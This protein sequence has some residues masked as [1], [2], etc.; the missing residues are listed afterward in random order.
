MWLLLLVCTTV[1]AQN[2]VNDW[3]NPAMPSFNTV[4]AHAWFVPYNNESEALKNGSSPN[5]LSLDGT[6]KFNL[7]N[8]VEE[9]PLDFYK[10]NFNTSKWND[11]KVP[12]SWQTEGFDKYIFT[13][14]EYPIPPNPPF[15]PKEF[16]PV[17]SYK[18]SFS[19]PANWNGKNVFIHLGAVNSF[20]YLWIND[21]YVGFS[22]DSKTAA[23]FDISPFLKKGN[24]TVSIQVF[25]FSDGTY[26]EGQDMWK[27]S[28]I[29][30]SVYLI[31]R[32]KLSIADF[33][34]K[35]TLD[36]KYRDGLFDLELKM[37]RSPENK[38]LNQQIQIKVIDE[39]NGNAILLDQKQNIPAN[40]K[41]AIKKIFND[42]KKWNAETPNLY[43]LVINTLTAEGKSIESISR[44]IGFRTAE[45]KHGLFLINGV[46]V[47][48]KGVN[49]HEFNSI[50]GKVITRPEM[51]EDIRIFKQY[52]INAV[53]SSHYPNAPEW[54]ELCDQYGIYVV[55]EVNIE[56][57]GMSFSPL[58]TL[59]DKPEWLKAYM[60]RTERMFEIN[61]NF[62]SI[63]TW[64]LGNE[65]E[66][67]SNM[68]ATYTY[69]K[70]KDVTR[71]VAYEPASRTQYSDIFFPM[72]KSLNLMQEYVKEWRDK[73]YI[74]CE[75]AHMMGNGGGNLKDYWDLIYKYEQ[76]QGGYIWD[77]SDQAFRIK[78]SKGRAI[79]GYGR[80][81]GKV[82]ETSDTSFC[83][84]G[85]FTSDRQPHP[86][87]FELKRVYQN[88]NFEPTPF[89]KNQITIFNRFD[90][91]DL[92]QYYFD[93]YIKADG[94]IVAQG[95]IE[96]FN[97]APHQSKV[98]TLKIPELNPNPGTEYF[99]TI[100]GKTK[101]AS[102]LLPANYLMAENQF[103]LPVFK[104]VSAKQNIAQ[105]LL[106]MKENDE[107]AEVK[108]D[109]FS[110]IFNK[111]TGWLEAYNLQ[112]TAIMK[113]AL[114]PHFWRAATDNDI[115]NSQ[116]IRCAMWKDPI[117]TASLRSFTVSKLNGSS[118]QI[119]TRHYLPDVK[120]FYEVTYL[121]MG[122][123]EIKVNASM[124][125]S[126]EYIPEM[127]RFGMRMLLNKDFENVKWLGRGPFDN[128]QDRNYS[129][130]IDVYEMPADSLF[131]PYARAQESGYR[132]D[133][134][135]M[136]LVNKSGM[137]L[138]AVGAPTISTGVL[139]FDMAKLDYYKDAPE[140][141]HGGSMT[142]EDFVW[143]NIDY[144][145]M[146]VGGDNSWG[147][148]PHGQ[149]LLPYRDYHYTFTIKP[150]LPGDNVIE[151]SKL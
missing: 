54:Y 75:Y 147:A 59:S 99:I 98:V 107:K 40:G 72:Y 12:A 7:V 128:Y 151:T 90:F 14:V 22:K 79:W 97:L 135:W 36:D 76:L 50:T 105:P 34:V 145:Q 122:N 118:Y 42:I 113:E 25:R 93:W 92:N 103:K 143:W 95:R 17:G 28:G 53:R 44:K 139:H 19:V 86:Q 109:Q 125:A 43:T 1:I 136:S 6:W 124:T 10:N 108:G 9:R 94:K 69:L 11:I 106:S 67:G 117:K 39:S 15:V 37:N 68:Q 46:A 96:D 150:V 16:N 132:T 30:R 110:A 91:T 33:F 88:V 85:L 49:R 18:R 142:N 57:E 27:L 2:K 116:Q 61:K 129:A 45:I 138:M 48:F 74:Q 63:I 115:G 114:I 148:K 102:P 123:G 83:A 3:E 5:V 55:D 56:C 137:G 104:D 73:P 112:N 111:K 32:P 84:D 23:E 127:P 89:T 38:E 51:I 24:N 21:H 71:P 149:Y 47:K 8:T 82:G 134:R 64:S 146:G 58:K 65:S 20:F 131:Y 101:Y 144:K 52:N 13:D 100:N 121:V 66:N 26:L 31:A 120:A 130:D 62:T 119:D 70:G 80:D 126:K 78:D 140:N 141:N 4:P 35:A 87:A 41:I 60:D 77:F 133:V 29:E 81:M